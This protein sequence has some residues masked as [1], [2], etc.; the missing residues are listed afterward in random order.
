MDVEKA[1]DAV[2]EFEPRV[3]LPY[4]YRGKGGF[5]DIEK[6]RELVARNPKIEVRLLN[7]YPD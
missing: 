6:F 2:L 1:A 5:S 4:H 7:W 3:V